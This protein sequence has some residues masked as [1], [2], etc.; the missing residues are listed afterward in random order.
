MSNTDVLP[1]ARYRL[2]FE[3]IQ[4]MR[5]PSYA[6]SA[7]RGA[8]GHA[9]RQL[10]CATGARQCEGCSLLAQCPYTR[11][12]EPHGLPRRPGA[13]FGTMRQVPVPYIIEAPVG[14]RRILSVG[15]TL[16][17]NMVLLGEVIQQLP[18]LLLAWRRA[19]MGGIGPAE[20]KGHLVAVDYLG[21]SEETTAVYG[22]DSQSIAPHQAGLTLPVA[23]RADLH[24]EL[25]TAL[26][27]EQQK[28]PL[29]ARQ[30]SAPIFLRHLLR[31]VALLSELYFDRSLGELTGLNIAQLNT[32]CDAVADE[33][34]LR[35][36]DWQRYSSRQRQGMRLGGVTGHWLLKAVPQEL[37]SCVYL[38]QWLHA[39]KETVFG[40][41]RY[42]ITDQPWSANPM[43]SK[44]EEQDNA[45]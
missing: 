14:H 21:P 5:L 34:R 30:L 32:Q 39:G 40:L 13:S 16:C 43:E 18:L 35:W 42:R 28:Q 36:R 6:G 3:V 25:L 37:Q 31:R 17:F 22:R 1:I 45:L 41:G 29:A 12:F 23:R 33:R 27:I 38:G 15:D 44:V 24:L 9:L 11:V 4:P 20:G 10:A 26:R 7:L 19:F 8:F 2:T